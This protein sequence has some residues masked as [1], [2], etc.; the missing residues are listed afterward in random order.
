LNRTSR[1][2]TLNSS[3][4]KEKVDFNDTGSNLIVKWYMAIKTKYEND[5]IAPNTT[6]VIK[7]SDNAVIHNKTTDV[8]GSLKWLIVTEYTQ[9]DM[10]ND[11]DGKD[12]GEKI[13]F[14]PHNV[15][16]TKSGN[17]AYANPEPNM[18]ES[19][20]VV[21][22][23]PVVYTT[24]TI[25]KIP[26]QGNVTVDGIQYPAPAVFSWLIGDTHTISVDSPESCGTNC[27]YVYDYWDDLGTQNHDVIVG[28]ADT[29]ITAYY[30]S[31]Y[32]S[33]IITKGLSSENPATVNF[34]QFGTIFKTTTSTT[35]SNWSDA[36]SDLTISDMINVSERE[37]Y[38]T[39]GNTS[40]TVD[41]AFAATVDYIHQFKP[42]IS[43]VGTDN[44]HTVGVIHSKD[45]TYDNDTGI[46]SSWSD[47]V[48]K[49]STLTFDECTSGSP[50]R[51]TTDTRTWTVASAFNATIN[52]TEEDVYNV[53]EANYKPF[54]ALIFSIILFLVGAYVTN[55][56]P[57]R[58]KVDE[59]RTK[60]FNLI[61]VVMPFVIIEAITG[62]ASLL[63]G[64]LN[65]PPL[66]GPG[67]IVDLLILISGLVAFALVYK[68][69]IKSKD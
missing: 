40:W 64:F 25:S 6:I 38:R 19:K 45:A 24:Y 37:R 56:K 53:K 14:T 13:F 58:L 3:F 27:R 51:C 34:T 68:G 50:S 42:M 60:M 30:Y 15:T 32:K 52:Y 5:M 49:N 23:L 2:I 21:I 16:A 29:V 61:F 62:I 35:W 47:W 12:P 54:V 41:S 1:L 69:K 11:H 59:R 55:K 26:L 44:T 43:L 39:L 20:E 36:G 22:R 33:T 65:I 67:T 17:I 9:R 28:L 8:N 66:I 48:D 7:D 31:Q 57:L 4:Q 18:N 63:T 10:N 46:V